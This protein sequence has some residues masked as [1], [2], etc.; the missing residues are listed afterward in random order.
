MKLSEK[1]SQ[2]VL[3]MENSMEDVY[4]KLESE[5][6]RIVTVAKDMDYEE[7]PR[8]DN[9]LRR[10]FAGFIS[11]WVRSENRLLNEWHDYKFPTELTLKEIFTKLNE[12]Y[13]WSCK[14]FCDKCLTAYKLKKERE[15]NRQN[16]KKKFK[17][18]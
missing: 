10:L 14:C 2:K 7:Y 9:Q 3:L 16:K 8:S 12:P 1:E 18:T 17:N 11:T 5:I 4:T 6:D 15:N 13:V